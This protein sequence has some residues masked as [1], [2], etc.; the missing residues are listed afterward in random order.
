M[1][2]SA[3][4]E[5]LDLQGEVASGGHG[6]GECVRLRDQVRRL[7]L[8][9]QDQA[10]TILNIMED[11]PPDA[12]SLAIVYYF[13][14]Q[15]RGGEKCWKLIWNRIKP[16]IDDM[17]DLPAPLMTP[18][19]WDEFRARRRTQITNRGAPPCDQTLNIELIY[20]KQL[21]T[22]AVERELIKRNPLS[23][24]RRVG[25]PYRRETRL[26]KGDIDRLLRQAEDLVDGRLREGDDDGNRAAQ[27]QAFILCIFD[28]MLRFGEARGLRVD[29]IREDGTGELFASETK[30]KR[31][32]SIPVTARTIEAIQKINRPE[33]TPYVFAR[34]AKSLIG[35]T[36]MRGW[37]RWACEES[38][39]DE[40]ATPRDRQVRPHDGRAGG[41]TFAD[42]NGARATAIRD[43]LG[44]VALATTEIYLRSEA[45]ENARHVAEVMALA[46]EGP[47]RGPRRVAPKKKGAQI[48]ITR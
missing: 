28:S 22:F 44:H 10:K 43:A 19:K 29:R 48:K 2:V 37:F 34:T 47:R 41:A 26:S 1:G 33:G 13:W 36:T 17:G 35:A 16:L 11:C 30:S 38:G 40:R 27:L 5:S 6:C 7:T 39:V 15:A 9:A 46:T 3:G 4:A 25:K 8:I 18:L 31:W 21:L 32:R 23:A 14:S 24:A 20:A 42:E 12:P 45:Q